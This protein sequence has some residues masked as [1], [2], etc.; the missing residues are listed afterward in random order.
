MPD[1]TILCW[2]S[3]LT[4]T[5]RVRVADFTVWRA[6]SVPAKIDLEQSVAAGAWR[7][8][9]APSTCTTTEVCRVVVARVP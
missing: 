8:V 2:K 5:G 7:I 9:A 1:E 3:S 4:P 6:G